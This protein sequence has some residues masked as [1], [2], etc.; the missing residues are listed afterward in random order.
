MQHGKKLP[1]GYDERIGV[2]TELLST[3]LPDRRH[4]R[5]LGLR[6]GPDDFLDALAAALTAYRAWKGEGV[7]IPANP[8]LDRKGLRMVCA[9]R[10]IRSLR[11]LWSLYELERRS[12]SLNRDRSNSSAMSFSSGR[13]VRYSAANTLFGRLSRA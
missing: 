10:N 13:T 12:S 8:Q 4:V 6:I 2:L 5:Q 7:R 1:E 9:S 3:K 11:S